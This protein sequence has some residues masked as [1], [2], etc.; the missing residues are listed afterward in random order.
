MPYVSPPP[1]GST[2]RGPRRRR[3]RA[4]RSR[5]HCYTMRRLARFRPMIWHL[6]EVRI[7]TAPKEVHPAVTSC[8]VHGQ[9]LPLR[10]RI[11][12]VMIFLCQETGFFLFFFPS[13]PAAVTFWFQEW[14]HPIRVRICGLSCNH[15]P[16]QYTDSSQREPSLQLTS[17]LLISEANREAVR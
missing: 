17:S 10:R 7:G 11:D 12:T 3:E 8:C 13:I 2:A 6:T 16:T 14:I 4:F 9:L 15:P 1:R 5:P